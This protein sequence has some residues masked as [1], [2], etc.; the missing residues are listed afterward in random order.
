MAEHF[1]VMI[2]LIAPLVLYFCMNTAFFH[3]VIK[4]SGIHVSKRLLYGVIFAI[5]FMLCTVFSILEFNL[6]MNWSMILVLLAVE[7]RIVFR[8]PW[9]HAWAYAFIGAAIGLAF[10]IFAR[11]LCSIVLDVP[12]HAFNVDTLDER[13]LKSIPIAM[14]F[15]FGAIVFTVLDRELKP[16]TIKTLCENPRSLQFFLIMSACSFAYLCTV[17]LLY[18]QD[19]NALVLKLWGLKAA[20]S[21]AAIQGIAFFFAYRSAYLI[22]CGNESRQLEHELEEQKRVNESLHSMAMH[23]SLTGCYTRAYLEEA[24]AADL[25]NSKEPFGIAFI[26]LDGLKTVNDTYGHDLGNEYLLTIANILSDFCHDD[27]DEYL[28]RHGGDEFVAVF[29]QIDEQEVCARLEEFE[30]RLRTENDSGRFAYPLSASCGITQTIPGESIDKVLRR[31]DA[32]MY[33]RKAARR[34]GTPDNSRS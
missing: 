16:D 8:M 31:A 25:A 14:G 10:T 26:D 22:R 3:L 24:L 12:Q 29:P 13:N 11:S 21:G 7:T 34:R 19:D 32:K 20:I 15:G 4:K 28:C 30:H 23:D 1:N 5:N 18:Q 2:D 6:I 17:L 9:S 27:A 33:E